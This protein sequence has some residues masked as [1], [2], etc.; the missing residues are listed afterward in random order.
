MEEQTDVCKLT[1]HTTDGNLNLYV[2]SKTKDELFDA[3]AQRAEEVISTF[4]GVD[5]DGDE[6]FLNLDIVNFIG[7][8][9][10]RITKRE[11]D[12]NG[13]TVHQHFETN[14]TAPRSDGDNAFLRILNRVMEDAKSSDTKEDED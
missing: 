1:I 4:I 11:V 13:Y 14:K 10:G 7:A 12:K 2:D 3:L 8:A 5:I 6:F 9:K